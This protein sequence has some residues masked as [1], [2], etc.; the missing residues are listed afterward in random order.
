MLRGALRW[1]G[2]P[3]RDCRALGVPFGHGEGPAPGQRRLSGRSGGHDRLPPTPAAEPHAGAK[4]ALTH[5]A[6]VALPLLLLALWILPPFWSIATLRTVNIQDDIGTS[7][8]LADRLPVRAF[9]GAAL[10]RGEAPWWMPGIYTGFPALAQVEVGVLYPSNL[11]LFGLLDPYVA[12]AYAQLLPLFIAGLG[13]WALAAQYG[14][15]VASR[16]LAAGS[17]ALCGFFISHFRQLNM[18]DAAAWIPLLVLL[19]ER[20]ARREA[21][22]A[23]LAL[24]VVWA[25]QLLAGHP[26]ISYFSGLVLVAYFLARSGPLGAQPAWLRGPALAF[27]LALALGT[28]LAAA[29]LLPGFELA[30]ASRRQ[31]GLQLASATAFSPPAQS[32]ALFLFPNRFGDPGDISYR[33]DGIPWEQYGY[34][35]LAPVL[36][37]SVALVAGWAARW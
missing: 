3:S 16:L 28:L 36:L 19:T 37:A 11:L 24:A 9:V 13:A 14:L 34:L 33:L 12:I 1:S 10:R 35:G 26:Q 2:A 20:I 15:P 22:R 25:L 5:R 8:L 4:T 30:Q 27:A 7:D 18:V 29:Q 6:A 17:F 32:L 23:P 21:G 31:G